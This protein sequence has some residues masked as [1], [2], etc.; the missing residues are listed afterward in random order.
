[1]KLQDPNSSASKN[2]KALTKAMNIRKKIIAFHPDQPMICLSE[3]RS[4]IVIIRRGEGKNT[5]WAIHNMTSSKLCFAIN[6][7]LSLKDQPIYRWR[8]CLNDYNFSENRI[9]LEPYSV[10]WLMSL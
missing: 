10:K 9:N 7:G 4:D 2:I 1:M 8:E 6:E 3:N 5:L